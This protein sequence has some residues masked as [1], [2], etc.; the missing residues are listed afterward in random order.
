VT[1]SIVVA[2][3]LIVWELARPEMDDHQNRINE[4]LYSPAGA[5]EDQSTYVRVPHCISVVDG[6]LGATGPDAI[7]DHSFGNIKA[8][9]DS[10]AGAQAAAG[11]DPLGPDP[12]YPGLFGVTRD[13]DPSADALRQ[14]VDFYSPDT[15][16]YTIFD[17]SADGR[18]L[19]VSSFGINSTAQNSF[20]GYDPVNNPVRQLLSFNVD[21]FPE[22]AF[23]AC[24]GNITLGTDPGQC[25]AL[26]SFVV[27][28][29]GRP[30][31]TV[32]CTLNGVAI[33]SPFDFA[34]GVNVVNCAASNTLGSATCTFTMT[35]NDTEAPVASASRKDSRNRKGGEHEDDDDGDV[36]WTLQAS[37]NCDGSALQIYVKDSA[38]GKCGGTFVAGPY[39]RGAKVTL[40][41]NKVHASVKRGSDGLAAK[42]TT[43]G[44]PVLVVTDSS[45]NTSCTVV[46][47][48]KD[49]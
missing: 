49:E 9:A 48:P 42:I 2:G 32:V 4:L 36:V 16:N 6:P 23:T 20:L 34:K 21:A 37:D 13:G 18:I 46:Q 1:F 40:S 8:I 38:E 19:T 35:V 24:P 26:S 22:P 11:V 43:K 27:A 45:G 30:T 7:T 17:V 25:A 44:N 10:L 5:T 39:A 29:S 33:N 41:R 28:A 47:I 12:N 31:P 15:F 3:V 14:P